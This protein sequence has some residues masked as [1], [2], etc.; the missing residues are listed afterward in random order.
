MLKQVKL[1][2]R[3]FWNDIFW[4]QFVNL[5]HKVSEYNEII[6]A[7]EMLPCFM[8]KEHVN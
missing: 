4:Q 1:A 2:E 8:L 5:Y 6:R 7:L 3:F